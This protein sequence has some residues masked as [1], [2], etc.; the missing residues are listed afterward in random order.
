MTDDA[1]LVRL[2]AYVEEAAAK[3]ILVGDHLQL[4][5]PSARAVPS[6]LLSPAIPKPCI[7]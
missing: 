7:T 4:R 2:G 3:L 6:A 5:R 1:D